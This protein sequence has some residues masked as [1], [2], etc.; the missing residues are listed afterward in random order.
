MV[1]KFERDNSQGGCFD[2]F[3]GSSS[4]SLCGPHKPWQ[5]WTGLNMNLYVLCG[6]VPPEMTSLGRKYGLR[7]TRL[8]NLDTASIFMSLTT[9][10]K[11]CSKSVV[12]C[13]VSKLVHLCLC[14]YGELRRKEINVFNFGSLWRGNQCSVRQEVT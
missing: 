7:R 5:I 3:K 1:S 4:C 14:I 11:P 13:H 6:Q 8:V 2:A 10:I 12:L 9:G